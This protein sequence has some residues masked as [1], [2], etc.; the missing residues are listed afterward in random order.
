MLGQ[1]SRQMTWVSVQAHILFLWQ[2][3]YSMLRHSSLCC[4]I[5]SLCRDI[6]ASFFFVVGSFV[7]L[8][9]NIS[10]SLPFVKFVMTKLSQ[11][12]FIFVTT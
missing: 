2:H 7:A 10:S 11:L 8:C 12:Q 5:V 1:K 4:D 6:V 9:R 3:Y